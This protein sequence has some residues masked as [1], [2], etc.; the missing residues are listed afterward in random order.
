[1]NDPVE[2]KIEFKGK[3]GSFFYEKEGKRFAESTFVMSGDNK[4]IIDHTEV[5]DRL[6]GKGIG[7]E[8]VKKEVAY[9]REHKIK[10]LP[11]CPFTEAMFDKH[12]EFNDV[13]F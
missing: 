2:I 7:L 9:A 10:I 11:L 1:M 12:P 13:R 3:R 5:D 4:M 8:L 6:K